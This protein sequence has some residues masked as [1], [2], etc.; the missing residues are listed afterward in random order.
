[1]EH[2]ANSRGLGPGDSRPPSPCRKCGPEPSPACLHRRILRGVQN[3]QPGRWRNSSRADSSKVRSLEIALNSLSPEESGARVELQAAL[4]RAKEV[5]QKPVQRSSTTPDA[6]SGR[7][8]CEGG[9]VGE[10]SGGIGGDRWCGGGCNQESPC[11]SQS[12]RPKRSQ[13][14][15]A[16][17]R[18]QEFHRSGREAISEVGRRA[19]NR[20][21]LCW[22]RGLCTACA[23]GGQRRSFRSSATHSPCCSDGSRVGASSSRVADA[24]TPVPPTPQSIS[25]RI[26]SPNTVEEAALWMRCRQQDMRGRDCPRFRRGCFQV[27]WMS[28]PR[29]QFS[30]VSGHKPPSSVVNIGELSHVLRSYTA[31][32][33]FVRFAGTTHRRGNQSRPCQQAATDARLR[34][35][36]RAMDSD[37]ES[38]DEC[39]NVAS[40]LEGDEQN[41]QDTPHMDLVPSSPPSEVIR[42][43]EAGF[44]LPTHVHD[45]D[46]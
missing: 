24:R 4:R 7:S 28:S 12:C 39:R 9:Q 36:Q 11:Q 10:S 46:S 5:T 42:E 3:N 15:R 17:R 44:V 41:L 20:S 18:L 19:E 21:T 35:L 26:S 40:R 8:S 1:M 27:G 14:L 13:C 6:A 45:R 38:E 29:E 34:A 22:R 16:D 37:S 43:L 32:Q 23:S 33:D 30:C 2:D 25:G 31:H